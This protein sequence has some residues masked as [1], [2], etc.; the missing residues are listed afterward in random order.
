MLR[1]CCVRDS[2]AAAT[3]VPIATN[4]FDEETVLSVDEDCWEAD[5]FS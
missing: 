5:T 2:T 4:E 1:M 3:K